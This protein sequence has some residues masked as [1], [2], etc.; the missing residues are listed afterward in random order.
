M[1]MYMTF[2]G[3]TAEQLKTILNNPKQLNQ[4]LKEAHPILNID[5]AWDGINYLLT[6]TEGSNSIPPANTIFGG[7]PIK[8][9]LTDYGPPRYFKVD[10]VRTLATA[11]KSTSLDELRQR[12][13]PQA[14]D[15][16]GIYPDGIWLREGDEAFEY[17]L[18]FYQELVAFFEELAANDLAV[19]SDIG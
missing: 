16:A 4:L 8:G 1:G 9:I 3:V 13:D 7:M 10:E 11:L 18:E 5:K 15:D 6:A 2:Y 17:L 12:Y 14:M 19:I